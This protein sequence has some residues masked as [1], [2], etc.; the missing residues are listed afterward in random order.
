MTTPTGDAARTRIAL[1][2]QFALFGIVNVSWTSRLPSLMGALGI[3]AAELGRLL[4]I[5]GI[6]SLLGA[7][8]GGA[9]VTRIGARATLLVGVVGH[10][11]G[12][13]LLAVSVFTGSVPLFLPGALINGV[14]SAW[15]NLSINVSAAAVEQRIGRAIMPHFHAMFSVGAALGALIAAGFAR[16]GLGIGPQVVAVIA[17]G[18]AIRLL[19]IRPATAITLAGDRSATKGRAAAGE[20]LSAWREPRT[21]LLGL[22]L[23]AASLTEGTAGTWMPLAVVEGFAAHEDVGAL[24]YGSFVAAMTLVRAFGTRLIDRFGRVVVLRVSGGSAL[25]GLLLFVTGPTLAL[26]WAGVILWGFGAAL[27][28]P[29]ATTA[30]ADDPLR[31]SVRVS[32]VASFSTVTALAAPPLLGLLAAEVGTRQALLVV[33]VFIVLSLSLA[34]A[35]RRQVPDPAPVRTAAAD[36]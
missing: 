18:T 21:L 15:S 8:S 9:V 31:A 33:G 4:L 22:V 26:A 16:A 11:V 27:G 30:A 12:F 7:L 29:I 5:G 23:M 36:V 34:G 20:A 17:A 1:L 19:L 6:G 2:C 3:D 32:V 14:S 24:A 13:G 10:A 25:V 28:N 35:A